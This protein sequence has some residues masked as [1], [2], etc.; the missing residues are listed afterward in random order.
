MVSLA[1][2]LGVIRGDPGLF[3]RMQRGWASGLVRFW[4]VEVE[5]VGREQVVP[6]QPYVVMSNHLSWVD[7]PVLFLALPEPPGFLA[8]RELTRVPFL[9]A[10]LRNGG[11][12]IIDRGHRA[13]A[14]ASLDAAAQEVRSGKTVLIFPEGTRGDSATI[15][16]FKKGGFHLAKSAQVPILPVGVRGCRAVFPRGGLLVRPGRVEVHIGAP[17]DV[18]RVVDEQLG[19]LL[20]DARARVAELSAMPFR[21]AAPS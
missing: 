1:V 9:A 6:G 12:V 4:G 10:A 20:D 5:V 2:S 3:R 7:I 21:E 19:G 17:I 13:H 16:A 15:G 14:R 18:G 8:K 11:H